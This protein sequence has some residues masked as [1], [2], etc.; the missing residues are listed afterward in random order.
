MSGAYIIDRP[1]SILSTPEEVETWIAEL[2]KL[3]QDNEE[4]KLELSR[5]KKILAKC[6]DRRKK[7]K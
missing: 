5:A 1:V 6:K 7:K 2:E 3:D 4:V